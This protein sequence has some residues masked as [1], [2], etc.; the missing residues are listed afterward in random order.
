MSGTSSAERIPRLGLL[1]IHAMRLFGPIETMALRSGF[2]W[3]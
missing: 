1:R 3:S 2:H